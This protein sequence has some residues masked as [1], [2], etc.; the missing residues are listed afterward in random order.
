MTPKILLDEIGVNSSPAPNSVLKELAFQGRVFVAVGTLAPWASS[1]GYTP[2]SDLRVLPESRTQMW[3][4]NGH[5]HSLQT[6]E[7]FF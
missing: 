7:A 5:F 2:T 1:A 6:P 4:A 3:R